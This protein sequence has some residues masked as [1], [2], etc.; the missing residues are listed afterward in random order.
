VEVLKNKII[1]VLENIGII[2]LF[3]LTLPFAALAVV[4]TG[5]IVRLDK[6]EGKK[7]NGDN[8]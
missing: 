3:I 6:W 1:S 4:S 5:V 7:K 8:I 2:F